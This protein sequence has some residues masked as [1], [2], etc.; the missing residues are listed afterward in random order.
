MRSRTCQMG[1][2]VRSISCAVP[3]QISKLAPEAPRD[4]LCALLFSANSESA[5][6][7]GRRARRR[8]RPPVRRWSHLSTPLA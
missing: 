8:R 1:L 6:E 5:G 3:E 2:G 4:A 7:T